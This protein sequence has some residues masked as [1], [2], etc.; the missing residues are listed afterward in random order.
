MKIVSIFNNKGGVGKTTYIYHIAHLLEDEG[1]KVLLVDLDSQC[2]LS[3]YSMRDQDLENSWK[4]DRG[5][6]IWNAVEPLYERTGDFRKRQPSK[7]KLSYPDLYIIP[8]D[9]LLSDFEDTLGDSWNAAKGGDAGALR[10]Q[11][12]IYRFVI[13][14]AQKVNADVVMVDLGPNLGAL[15]RAMLIASDFFIVPISPDLFSIRGTQNLGAKLETWRREWQQCKDSYRGTSVQ[16]PVG[17]PTFLGYVTQQH[18][19]RNTSAGMTKGWNIFGKRV[20]KAVKNNIIKRLDPIG[21][22]H[23]WKNKSWCIG[24]IPNLHSL[25]PYSL[26]ARKPVFDCNSTDGLKGSH[27]TKAK[28]SKELFTPIVNKLLQIL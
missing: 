10:V 4:S 1:K 5:N 13:W 19:V 16:L 15:N 14:A 18:N 11:T 8:G 22:V 24:K 12:A 20:E 25:I 17:K 9:I 27:I 21:Q 3:A 26:E 7:I 2:N 6:S 23:H 28:Q